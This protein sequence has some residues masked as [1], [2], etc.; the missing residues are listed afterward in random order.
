MT[1]AHDIDVGLKI[2]CCDEGVI[3]RIKPPD[4]IN[5]HVFKLAPREALELARGL[6]LMADLSVKLKKEPVS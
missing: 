5:R 4:S 3:L 1:A 2:P 6:Q